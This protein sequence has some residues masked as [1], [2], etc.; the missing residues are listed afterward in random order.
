MSKLKK[1]FIIARRN[2]AK[3]FQFTLNSTCG[4]PERICREWQR[5]SFHNLS[6]TEGRRFFYVHFKGNIGS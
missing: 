6:N 3:T 4:L 1:P 5:V 2:D